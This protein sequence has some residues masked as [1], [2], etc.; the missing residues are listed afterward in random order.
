MLTASRAPLPMA[1]LEV[2]LRIANFAPRSTGLYASGEVK[3]G[4]GLA[5][6]RVRGKAG[7]AP[8]RACFW[9][10]HFRSVSRKKTRPGGA[11]WSYRTASPNISSSGIQQ[12][13][14]TLWLQVDP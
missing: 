9:R 14:G 5:A 7:G 11:L 13:I 12:L 2:E 1:F 8:L 10:G 4:R 3:H 6:K